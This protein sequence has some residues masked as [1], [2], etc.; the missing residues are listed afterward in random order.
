MTNVGQSLSPRNL[1]FASGIVIFSLLTLV[2]QG[3]A[4]APEN[5]GTVSIYADFEADRTA[6]GGALSECELY[7]QPL[8]LNDGWGTAHAEDLG[9]RCVPLEQ[10][11]E[12][13]RRGDYRNVHAVLIVKDGHLVYEEYF[14]GRDRRPES[15]DYGAMVSHTFDRESL[16]TTRSAGKSFTSAL[17]GVAL[18]AGFIDSLDAP[19]LRYFPEYEDI[20]DD[21]VRKI[22][23]RHLLTMSAGL[24]WN[25]DELSYADPGNDERL[26]SES[27][28][29]ARFL[30]NRSVV[31]EPG[32]QWEYNSGLSAMIG[33]VLHRAT[34]E[35]FATYAR[36]N[37]FEPLEIK[38]FDWT[39]PPAWAEHPA[40]VWEGD[41]E[42]PKLD[43]R[44]SQPA[45]SLWLRPR[46]MLKFGYVYLYRGKWT[47]RQVIPS[48][49]VVASLE[50]QI[51]RFSTSYPN[52]SVRRAAYGYQWWF[53]H[54]ELPYGDVTVH[55]AYGNG[56]QKIW[57]VPSLGLAA[58]HLAGNYNLRG[59]GWEAERLLYERILPWAMD[60]ETTYHHQP[61]MSPVD[62]DS[63]DWQM[64]E[65]STA[66]RAIYPGVYLEGGEQIRIRDLDGRLQLLPPLGMGPLDLVPLGEHTFAL[67]VVEGALVRQ[68]YVPDERLLF[69]VD[70][71][72]DVLRYEFR[73]ADGVI[74]VG[75]PV[76]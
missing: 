57:V 55:S 42:W 66:D 60:I 73:G 67:G 9:L 3:C 76:R 41:E 47:D 44:S 24:D 5:L 27:D 20:V 17:V 50:P 10:M 54:F 33:L 61:S 6:S 68:V 31:N 40:F 49:W 36:E 48:E 43:T 30:L 56:G 8:S 7:S 53:D 38:R 75:E 51:E 58:I 14:D 32:S 46:D 1:G 52:G 71:E 21:D 15:S 62:V 69:V 29:P 13:I 22:S 25:E 23:L 34:G 11:T 59:N 2:H 12:A 65:L 63:K 18:D 64:L 35:S 26:I 19:L 74:S 4:Q 39:G 16:H 28:D 72:G 45:G 37:L 70:R